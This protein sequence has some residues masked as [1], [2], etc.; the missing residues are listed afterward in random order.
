MISKKSIDEVM[1]ISSIEDVVG[2]FVRLKRS[3]S[4][5]KGLSPFVNEKTPSFFVVPAKN[6]FKCFSSGNGG[7][8][9][10]FLRVHQQMSYV[11]AI[12]WLAKKYNVQLRY[13]GAKQFDDG[14]NLLYEKLSE[15]QA[16]FTNDFLRSLA[17]DY[18]NSRGFT[19]EVLMRFGIGYCKDG[20]HSMYASR[21]TFPIQDL[22]GRV[23]SF[24]GR[25]LDTDG[26]KY[27]NGPDSPIY[28]KSD[29]LYNM[30]RAKQ[31]CAKL[32]V[33]YL[34]EGYTDVMAMDQYGITNVVATCGTAITP[35]Q[36]QVMRRFTGN[37]IVLLDGDAPGKKAAERGVPIMLSEGLNVMISTIPDDA[38]PFDFVMRQG[39]EG[40]D[41]L[42]KQDYIDFK[43]ALYRDLLKEYPGKQASVIKSMKETIASIPDAVT[44]SLYVNRVARLFNIDSRY[45]VDNVEIPVVSISDRES[46]V[47]WDERMLMTLC[48]DCHHLSYRLSHN[49][50]LIDT[51]ISEICAKYYQETVEYQFHENIRKYFEAEIESLTNGKHIGRNNL[52]ASEWD[53]VKKLLVDVDTDHLT[54]SLAF[55]QFCNIADRID[56]RMNNTMIDALDNQIEAALSAEDQIELMSRK[57][58]LWNQRNEIGSRIGHVAEIK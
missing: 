53:D 37:W 56:L 51:N 48:V 23:I 55:K 54:P 15:Q 28:H 1:K 50:Q 36:C 2:E 25:R 18:M 47:N 42:V 30:H 38:D 39:K 24:A 9:V 12:E 43:C 29:V 26:P 27:V 17:Q 7:D 44:R 41:D 34:V 33:G 8:V 31:I 21:V 19:A 4:S 5:L 45:L 58:A 13:D 10:T 3:G 35:K 6:L 16:K 14:R 40:I 57:M 52:S 46:D 49:N 22:M 32:D 11:E 20:S